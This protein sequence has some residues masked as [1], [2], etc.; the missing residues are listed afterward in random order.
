MQV[1][2]FMSP[3]SIPDCSATRVVLDRIGDKWS[4]YL[5]GSLCHG[6]K[7]FNALKRD[8]PA[9]SQRM[10]TLALRGLERDGLV[11]RTAHSSIPPRVEYALTPLGH[12]LRAPVEALVGWSNSHMVEITSARA[13]YDAKASVA[14]VSLVA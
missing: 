5:I 13:V 3:D 14:P 12:T 2:T 7:R 6:P 8:I 9:I 4:L 1:G 11:N 10:L